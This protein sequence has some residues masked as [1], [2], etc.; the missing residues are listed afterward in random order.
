MRAI[1]RILIPTDDLNGALAFF[2]T[3]LGFSFQIEKST[4]QGLLRSANVKTP[5]G[6]VLELVTP[7]PERA[8]LY[9]HPM[10]VL[11]VRDV[12][13]TQRQLQAQGIDFLESI[14][15]EQTWS[16]C[17]VPGSTPVQLQGAAQPG[18]PKTIVQGAAGV[19][20][21]LVP[22]TQFEATVS[23]FADTLGLPIQAQGEPVCDRRFHR[24]AQCLTTNGVVLEVVEPIPTQRAH[25]SSPVVSLTVEDLRTAKARLEADG[26]ALLSDIVDDSEQWGWFYF[27][28]PG[29]GTFQLQGPYHP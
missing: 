11:T 18:H 6:V 14:D 25:F 29:A 23:C 5:N 22:S 26:I 12:D 16:V 9:T 2:G 10:V 28:L 1:G 15:P 7:T 24:Y 13:S 27:R 3:T 8:H 17:R 4:G 20:W 19:E 21:I